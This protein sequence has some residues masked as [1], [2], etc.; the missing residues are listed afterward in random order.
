MRVCVHGLY[1]T[2]LDIPEPR[3]QLPNALLPVSES[4]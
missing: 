3:V 4:E 1:Y 2:Y